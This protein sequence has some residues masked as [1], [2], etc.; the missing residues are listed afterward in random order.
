MERGRRKWVSHNLSNA[1]VYGGLFHGAVRLPMPVL[2]TINGVG[3]SIAVTV[4]ADPLAGLLDRVAFSRSPDLRADRAA[5]RT[6]EAAL[7][8]RSPNPLD[9]LDDET[10][11]RLTRRAL[12]HYGDLAKLVASPLN[13]LPEIDERL[14]RRGA[15]DQPSRLSE[16]MFH[17]C[18]LLAE[19]LSRRCCGSGSVLTAR[20]RLRGGGLTRTPQAG[21]RVTCLSRRLRL[22]HGRN[23]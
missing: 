20:G 8:L 1:V 22:Y 11:A 4:L 3:N 15:P 23:C 12:G 10:F 14:A 2:L 13:R 18:A 21:D 19:F 9:D 7:P 6:T 16:Q 5:L 17:S